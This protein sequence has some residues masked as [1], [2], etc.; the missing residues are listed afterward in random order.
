M[1]IVQ[2]EDIRHTAWGE[3]GVHNDSKCNEEP[4]GWAPHPN[5]TTNFAGTMREEDHD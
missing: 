5:P 4:I 3:L 2:G 1:Q